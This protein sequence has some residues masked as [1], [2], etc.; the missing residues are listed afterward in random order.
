M[1]LVSASDAEHDDLATG[2]RRGGQSGIGSHQ[3]TV[4]RLSKRH[5]RRVVGREIVTQL[6]HTREERVVG[7]TDHRHLAESSNRPPGLRRG[8]V[9]ALHKS[10]KYVQYLDIE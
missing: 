3:S 8:Q 10:T 9:A 6:P 2:S 7:T 1:S 5:I 4:K